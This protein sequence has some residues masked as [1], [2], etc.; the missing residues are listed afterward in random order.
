M[1]RGHDLTTKWLRTLLLMLAWSTIRGFVSLLQNS[2]SASGQSDAKSFRTGIQPKSTQDAG[3]LGEAGMLG[4]IRHPHSWI[5]R[6]KKDVRP[7]TPDEG[8]QEVA[9]VVSSKPEI[10][11]EVFRSELACIG[12]RREASPP[13]TH[14]IHQAAKDEWRCSRV[15]I[16]SAVVR[17]VCFIA[18]ILCLRRALEVS[19]RGRRGR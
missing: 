8:V 3:R 18:G 4:Y 7:T 6:H 12:A 11:D 10:F 1:V 5:I 16:G 19:G 17:R 14:L 15:T 9:E 2:H 13:L